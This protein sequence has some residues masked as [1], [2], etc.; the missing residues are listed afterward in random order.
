MAISLGMHATPKVLSGPVTQ[1]KWS[2]KIEK[3]NSIKRFI[4]RTGTTLALVMVLP[5]AYG[6][7]NA[8]IETEI[9]NFN[10]NVYYSDALDYPGK[11]EKTIRDPR[12]ALF[13]LASVLQPNAKYF[14]RIHHTVQAELYML[15]GA[16]EVRLRLTE[17]PQAQATVIR[18]GPLLANNPENEILKAICSRYRGVCRH[19]AS[20]QI[21][22]YPCKRNHCVSRIRFGAFPSDAVNENFGIVEPAHPRV[23]GIIVTRNTMN[24]YF[25]EIGG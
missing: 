12:N 11:A 9:G 6:S 5:L 8:G 10:L 22:L 24:R 1:K 18:D 25:E 13:T 2:R 4:I 21:I 7:S 3:M 20:R 17:D 16:E 14:S 19:K 23:K 15:V